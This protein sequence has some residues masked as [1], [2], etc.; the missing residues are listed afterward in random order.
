MPEGLE[1][2]EHLA[3]NT[4]DW[5]AIYRQAHFLKSSVSVIRIRNMFDNLTKIEAHAKAHEKEAM[6]AVLEEVLSVYKEAHP[7]LL[8]E[9]DKTGAGKI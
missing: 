6:L 2:L 8:A 1:H 4:E 9:R 7:L 3:K 5:D